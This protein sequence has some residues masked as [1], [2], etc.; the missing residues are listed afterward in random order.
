MR[1]AQIAPLYE[2]VPPA[3]YGGTERVVHYLTEELVAIGHDV[4]LFAS[5]DSQTS[6]RLIPGCERAL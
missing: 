5:A 3:L 4:T 1:I 2:S 6:A